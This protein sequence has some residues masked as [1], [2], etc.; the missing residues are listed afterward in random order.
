MVCAQKADLGNV[1]SGV[2]RAHLL[3]YQ[4]NHELQPWKIANKL[5]FCIDCITN[6]DTEILTAQE[7]KSLAK[8]YDD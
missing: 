5:H 4:S 2:S 8:M 3:E 6:L 7:P 1:F